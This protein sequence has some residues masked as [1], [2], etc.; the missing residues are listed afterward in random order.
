[1]QKNSAY[2]LLIIL[3][4]LLFI[5]GS[6]LKHGQGPYYLFFSD[7]SYEYLLNSLNLVQLKGYGVGHIDHP[8]TTVQ[9]IGAFVLKIFSFVY[10]RNANIVNEVL[11]KPEE[12]LFIINKILVIINSLALFLLGMLTFKLSNN[13]YLSLLIQ[14][15]PFT[16]TQIF[17]GLHIVTPENFMIFVCLCFIGLLF[18]NQFKIDINKNPPFLWLILFSAVCGLGLATK[19]NFI[20][21]VFIPLIIIKG[22]KYKISFFVFTLLFFLFFVSPALSNYEKFLEWIKRL[23]INNG[24]YGYGDPTI[25]NFSIFFENVLKIFKKDMLFCILYIFSFATLIINKFI[26]SPNNSQLKTV[27]KER[28]L[29]FGVFAAF[30]LQIILVGK[31]YDQHYM[32]PSFMLC[33]T[34]IFLS[35]RIISKSFK[36]N[37]INFNLN[38]IYLIL[39]ISI[40]T[41]GLFQFISYYDE[42]SEQKKEAYKVEDFI[43]KNYS[44]ELIIPAFGGANQES[45]LAFA[46]YYAG[47]Q[48]SKYRYL[49]SQIL[50]S[51]I[52][53]N[54][55]TRQLY[56]ISDP[57]NIKNEILKK[58]KIILQITE[59][60]SV[61]I[62]EFL[63][64]LKMS[65]SLENT[66]YKKV[67][68][69]EYE[70]TVYEV[71]IH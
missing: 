65:Y 19:I 29:L 69:N 50:S 37:A 8:G 62:K 47:S 20:A 11:T 7:P 35:V 25:I 3:P 39:I 71:Y 49:F 40:S 6:L 14:L 52:F 51:N 61:Y 63:D 15:S 60:G 55:W 68:S 34:S 64:V 10:N 30:T 41:Y 38:H 54:A 46:T 59:Y 16:S 44:G 1:M 4:I 13:L 70:E 48:N 56:P 5:A 67:F 57:I 18:Y 45:A 2:F 28:R 9:V 36:K 32:I 53:Y 17:Y 33:I 24:R 58:K 42:V 66:T 31:H 22:L 21:L 26:Q 27:S 12:Y 43:K 23:T